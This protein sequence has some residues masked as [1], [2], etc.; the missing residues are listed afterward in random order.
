MDLAL[1]ELGASYRLEPQSIL[2]LLWLQT[3]F[4]PQAWERLC[5]GSVRLIAA[6]R[7]SLCADA[8]AAGLEVSCFQAPRPIAG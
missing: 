8:V 6:S 2:G 4:E 7:V 5:S 3:H 1:V